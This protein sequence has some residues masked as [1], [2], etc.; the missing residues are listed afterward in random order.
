MILQA[1]A[2][3]GPY[4]IIALIGAGSMGE[5]YRARDTRLGRE[6]ALKAL[7]REV[8]DDPTRRQRFEQEARAASV[9]NHP[10]IVAVYDVGSE[11]GI[12][13]LVT[14]LID[15]EQL[16][17]HIERGPLS[18]RRVIDLGAQAAEAL[19]T[20]HA[21]GF[22]HR[23]LKPENIMITRDDRVKIL[24][25]GLARQV[26]LPAG[27]DTISASGTQPGMLL[28]TVSYMSPEQ[29]RGEPVDH[30][31]D[32]F[33]LGLVLHEALSGRAVF[34]RDTAV[35]TMTAILREEAPGLPVGV[36]PA[37]GRVVEHC[38]EKDR[39]RRFQSARD[40]AFALKALSPGEGSSSATHVIS[41]RLSHALRRSLR[42]LPW[43]ACLLL[44]A[45]L[46]GVSLAPRGADLASY[47]FR[48]VATESVP[49][50]LGAWSP[51]GRSVAYIAHENGIP[52]VF[53]RSLEAAQPAR[54]TRLAQAADAPF[55]DPD[56]GKVYFLTRGEVW[57]VVRVGGEA[58][59][60]FPETAEQGHV[61]AAGIS[62]DG[63]TLAMWRTTRATGE[64]RS[65]LWLSSPPGAA[66]RKYEPSPFEAIG[67]FSPVVLG[68]APDGAKLLVAFRGLD[69]PQTW[70]VPFPEGSGR[71]RRILD[72][73]ASDAVLTFSWFPDSRHIAVAPY[74]REFTLGRN[75]A[76]WKADTRTGRA[77]P[78]TVG[79][80]PEQYPAVS[81]DGKSIL[82]TSGGADYDLLE[83]PLDGSLPRPLLASRRWEAWGAWSPVAPEFAYVTDKRGELEICI[84]NRQNGRELAVVRQR[85]FPDIRVNRF[86]NPTFSP[87]GTRLAFAVR[88]SGRLASIWIVPASGG[89][90]VRQIV[91]SEYAISPAWSPDGRWLAYLESR[92]GR[93]QLVKKQVAANEPEVVVHPGGCVDAPAWSP[94]GDWI[95]CGQRDGLAVF[96]ADGQQERRFGSEYGPVAAWSQD[97]SHLYVTRS[98]GDTR[99][100][101]TL[102]WESGQFRLIVEL[103]WEHRLL[104]P[105]LMT[106][107]FSM[108]PDGKS[109]TTTVLKVDTD[110]WIV[111][112][113][114]AQP[115][116]FDWLPWRRPARMID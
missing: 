71:P 37:L 102:R 83:I 97:G 80:S 94:A 110:L 82:Y 32:I 16:R 34:Y 84:R 108:A 14:E 57:S 39:E 65:S 76:I 73:F 10:N 55:W 31:S 38:L 3:L 67:A 85:D 86:M 25:F 79:N 99:Q 114:D 78:I 75:Q 7:P 103:P 20:A 27:N 47:R 11:D 90:P 87:D 22:V 43:V 89:V 24:D 52:Q 112:G 63:K 13:Y 45:A 105:N 36:P 96:S 72:G 88:E 98:N 68:W 70:L 115:G 62:P 93:D 81:P 116:L 48:P 100:F 29:V 111:E 4:E 106:R 101:G 40:L 5:V 30:R 44:A 49:E 1:G 56:A 19:A 64:A 8:G 69:G 60:V 46:V 42:A 107:T 51:D 104:A 50:R 53:L 109:I 12:A 18:P 9:L 95:L 33:S 66:V 74:P 2:R 21:A 113:F 15:G 17:R 35:E 58:Q 92:G 77:T 26:A 61:Y 23:D 91:S 59:P 28:G 54:I 6:V 41:G